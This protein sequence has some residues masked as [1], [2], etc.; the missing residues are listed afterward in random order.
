MLVLCNNSYDY[1]KDGKSGN[2]SNICFV[3]IDRQ[4]AVSFPQANKAVFN[5][6]L[7]V[8]HIYDVN[9]TPDGFLASEIKD[10]GASEAFGQL[11][12]E[13]RQ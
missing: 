1:E 4:G 7:I 10:C 8:G 9:F 13:L 5:K 3:R 12:Q 11:M 6:H 2:L